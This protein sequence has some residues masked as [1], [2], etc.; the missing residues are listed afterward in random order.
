MNKIRNLIKCKAHPRY[1]M[2]R[3]PRALCEDCWAL[4]LYTK[5]FREV[6]KELVK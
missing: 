5:Y 3:K 4:W 1:Q 6:A 2:K